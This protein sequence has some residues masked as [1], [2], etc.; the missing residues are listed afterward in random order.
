M[1]SA[2]ACGTD[3]LPGVTVIGLGLALMVAQLTTTLLAAA[4]AEH[5]GIA[6]GINNAVARAAGLLAVVV[7]PLAAGISG[8]DYQHPATFA[9]EPRIALM[10]CTGLLVAGGIIA[11]STIRNPT[12]RPSVPSSRQFCGVEG[13][14]LQPRRLADGV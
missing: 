4:A 5:A 9:A 12:A 1:T 13:P 3:V 2:A 8:D 10:I 11:G 14:P 6:S 7:L